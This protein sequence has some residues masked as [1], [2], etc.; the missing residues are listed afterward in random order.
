MQNQHPIRKII[1]LKEYNYSQSGAYFITICTNDRKQILS[2]I[3]RGDPCGRPESELYPEIKTILSELGKICDEKI[4]YISDKYNITIPKYTIMPNHIHMLIL[5]E[6]QSR[7][8]ARVAPTIG[9]IVGGYKSI[10][11]IEWLKICKTNNQIMGKI[12]QRSY[13]DHIIRNEQDYNI[14]WQYIDENPAKW[15]EDEYYK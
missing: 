11:S 13:N 14:K 8:T 3:R 9:T 1:R 12:W 2:E 10:V 6:Y 7:A 4:D 5:I 15:V